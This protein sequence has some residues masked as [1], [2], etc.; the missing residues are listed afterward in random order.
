MRLSS[1]R[2]N[3]CPF[4]LIADVAA[5]PVRFPVTFALGVFPHGAHVLSRKVA[6]KCGQGNVRFILEIQYSTVFFDGATNF[7][8][9]LSQPF[10]SRRFVN[11]AA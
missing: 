3:S 8:Y 9:F 7:R 11:F 1:K 5:T 4:R 6:K 2:N 10:L